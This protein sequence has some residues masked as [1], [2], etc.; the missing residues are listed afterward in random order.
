MSLPETLCVR[1]GHYEDQHAAGRTCHRPCSASVT[2]VLGIQAQC[3]CKVFMN[4]KAQRHQL[5]RK[6]RKLGC[7]LHI[8]AM[9]RGVLLAQKKPEEAARVAFNLL[10]AAQAYYE[11]TKELDILVALNP[12]MERGISG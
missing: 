8:L 4:W 6:K 11:V 1:C 9:S 2:Q 3:P 10:A 5:A 7:S 12:V